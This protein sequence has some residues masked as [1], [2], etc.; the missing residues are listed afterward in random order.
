[1][2]IKAWGRGGVPILLYVQHFQACPFKK[3]IRPLTLMVRVQGRIFKKLKKEIGKSSIII[4][5]DFD[6][7]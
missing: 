7:Y 2:I 3:K 1:M 5:F 4:I 6:R